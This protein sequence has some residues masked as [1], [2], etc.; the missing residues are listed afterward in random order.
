MSGDRPGILA[1]MNLAGP[2]NGVDRI[3]GIAL[4]S[5]QQ[6]ARHARPFS[7]H[8]L[9]R[10]GSAPALVL[11]LGLTALWLRPVW[12]APNAIV[13][14][15]PNYQ[16]SLQAIWYLAWWPHALTTLA[17][18]LATSLINYP[19]G[20]NTV[21]MGIGAPLLAI[22]AWPLTAAY[23]PVT[24]YNALIGVA[25]ATSAWAVYLCARAVVTH[26]TPAYIAGLAFLISP[27]LYGQALGH[28]GLTA[29][30]TVPL[31]VLW[32]N[33][34]VVQRRGGLLRAGLVLGGLV[35]ITF[36]IS[37][38]VATSLV[39]MLC[40]AAVLAAIM[41]P[42]TFLHQG[43][44]LA[45]VGA[46]AGIATFALIAPLAA[47]QFLGPGV[48]S[49]PIMPPGDFSA[50]LLGLVLPSFT[51]LVSPAAAYHLVDVAGYNPVD[52]GMYLGVPVIL[53]T[54][55]LALRRWQLAKV[56]L[57][58]VL[59]AASCIAELG[60][61]L[62]FSAL[63]GAGIPLPWSVIQAVPVVRDILPS[64]LALYV[65]FFAVL[66][67]AVSID[68]LL[69]T[70]HRP[71]ASLLALVL[72]AAWLPFPLAMPTDHYPIPEYFQHDA[73]R[74]AG[75]LL[76]LPF[77]QSVGESVAMEWQAVDGMSFSMVDGYFTRTTGLFGRF[78]HGP[79]LNVLTWDFWTLEHGGYGPGKPIYS[80]FHFIPIARW[81][82]NVDHAV[83]RAQP[84][85]TPKLH[86]DAA[87]Y[88]REHRVSTV[89]LGPTPYRRSMVR[90]LDELLGRPRYVAGVWVWR[91]RNH[92]W[93]A[94]A[95][96][97]REASRTL[98]RA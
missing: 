39:L 54:V 42:S 49:G 60:A 21:W 5:P 56:R 97:A 80:K 13:A 78:Y 15:L 90:F 75:V 40:L 87:Q 27:Y 62:H 67:L 3:D 2:K 46:V 16:D 93:G 74:H 91:Y 94:N 68:E 35:A 17:N 48:I 51:Q 58:T 11:Y 57:L 73:S 34:S 18:P 28:V 8:P 81:L 30:A 85:V 43:M 63:H 64:R 61:Q 31:T 45:K 59:L 22:I 71:W 76:V 19:H 95:R 79:P 26:A 20:V 12:A 52:F 37:E 83:V 41:C 96:Y 9:T 53:V 89:V 33:W 77:A 70:R 23:G 92:A 65:D 98:R 4:V 29:V 10:A 50:S 84:V 55:A 36:Y 44:R 25:L 38:E 6:S 72:V 24:S 69:A 47:W 66:I 86:A 82:G 32:V 7:T 88:F 14:G 1:Q